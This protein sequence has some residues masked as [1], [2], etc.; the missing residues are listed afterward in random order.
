MSREV[1][2]KGVKAGGRW[3]SLGSWEVKGSEGARSRW[4]RWVGWVSFRGDGVGEDVA[5]GG[6]V[7]L[8]LSALNCLPCLTCFRHEESI[9]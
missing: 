7:F 8:S 4:R 2:A 3:H 6:G 1:C 5:G 9:S